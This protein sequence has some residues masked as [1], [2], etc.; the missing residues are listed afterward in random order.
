MTTGEIVPDTDVSN[1]WQTTGSGTWETEIDEDRTSPNTSDYVFGTY[2]NGDNGDIDEYGLSSIAMGGGGEATSVT[3]YVYAKHGGTTGSTVTLSFWDNNSW[4]QVGTVVTPGASYA[5]ANR[6]LGSLS[7]DQTDLDAAKLRFTAG[8]P[9]GTEIYI[10]CCYIVVTY[11]SGWSH[12]IQ[13]VANAN[14]GKIM[15]ISKANIGKVQGV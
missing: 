2:A 8:L 12:K 10:A 1:T 9:K 11:T 14:I 6:T 4:Q 13:G 3:V 5:W 15:G 7:M